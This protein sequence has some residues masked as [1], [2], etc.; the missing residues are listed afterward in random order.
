MRIH[1]KNESWNVT[2][3]NPTKGVGQR[4]IDSVDGEFKLTVFV[5]FRNDAGDIFRTGSLGME[6]RR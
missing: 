1:S 4:H 3:D 6:R 2:E 5:G